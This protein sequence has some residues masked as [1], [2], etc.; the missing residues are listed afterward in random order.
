M[1]TYS[2]TLA[3]DFFEY[4]QRNAN[5]YGYVFAPVG[6]FGAYGGPVPVV[7]YLHPGG[8]AQPGKYEGNERFPDKTMTNS[9]LLDV[10]VAGGAAVIYLEY[11]LGSGLIDLSSQGPNATHFPENWISVGRAVQ[12]IK[13]QCEVGGLFY[14]RIDPAQIVLLGES[15]GASMVVHSQWAPRSWGMFPRSPGYQVSIGS[16]LYRNDHYARAM[17]LYGVPMDPATD[18]PSR[19]PGAA[20]S[21]V[22]GGIRNPNYYRPR[23]SMFGTLTGTI[24]AGQVLQI[25]TT[26]VYTGTVFSVSGSGAACTVVL[27]VE[28]GEATSIVNGNTLEVQG[29]TSNKLLLTAVPTV[30]DSYGWLDLPQGHREAMSP[31]LYLDQW[32]E[33]DLT[34]ARSI[35]LLAATYGNPSV[36]YSPSHSLTQMVT[37]KFGADDAHDVMMLVDKLGAL[38]GWEAEPVGNG[39]AFYW[40]SD[41]DTEVAFSAPQTITGA[42]NANPI[43]ITTSAAHFLN[44][45]DLVKVGQV[46]GNTNA[47]GVRSVN[48][49]TPTTF[50]LV[51]SAGNAAY[52]SGGGW[53][54]HNADG[55]YVVVPGIEAA[56]YD[57]CR[58]VVGIDIT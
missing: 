24:T 15:A 20:F 46:G 4:D 12:Y 52:T 44:T 47:N 23:I 55:S 28:K 19:K 58:D 41:A 32:T 42:S 21:V 43:V 40:G 26:A 16:D 22:P 37:G 27:L 50:E 18:D 25:E 45:G 30:L 17:V 5:S 54:F 6:G 11:P 56:I 8:W 1:G 3:T 57:W 34:V 10:F 35:P 13:D 7:V 48:V 31:I 33:G 39:S 14:G 51:G 2:R 53:C 38:G 49:L 29:A 9:T 36:M